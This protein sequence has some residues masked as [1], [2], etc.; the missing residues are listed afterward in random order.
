MKINFVNQT[1]KDVTEY[2]KLIRDIYEGK[3][4][5]LAEIIR[6][7]IIKDISGK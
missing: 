2:K 7:K 1:D 5:S 4:A 3:S 6:T